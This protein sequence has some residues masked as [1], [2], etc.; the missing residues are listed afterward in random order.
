MMDGD[1]W[2]TLWVHSTPLHCLDLFQCSVFHTAD[3]REGSEIDSTNF[4]MQ[5][6]TGKI[7]L[8]QFRFS[9]K[10]GGGGEAGI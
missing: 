10:D 9:M 8:T 3:V 1:S 4:T 6:V 5:Q 7:I 2:A